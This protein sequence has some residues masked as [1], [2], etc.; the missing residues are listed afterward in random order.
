MEQRTLQPHWHAPS[1]VLCQPDDR[2][3]GTLR[4]GFTLIELLVVIAIIGVLIGLL[5]PA[6]QQA[7]EAARR[8]SCGNSFKQMALALHNYENSLRHYPTA[9]ETNSA[10]ADLSDWSVPAKLLPFLEQVDLGDGVREAIAS[11]TSYTTKTIN[12]KKICN[13]RIDT[14]LC[15]S[16]I[17]NEPRGTDYY[18]LNVAVNM[19]TGTILGSG[20]TPTGDGAF[21][22]NFRGQPQHFSDGLS[23][24]LAMAEVR[25]WTP[26]V[27]DGGGLTT[28]PAGNDLTALQALPG[29]YKADSGHTEWC[30][31]RVHQSGFTTGF[32]PNAVTPINGG[33]DGDF[34][35]SREGG[36]R[37][38]PCIAVVTS[39]SYH[40]GGTV[41]VAMMDGSVSTISSEVPLAIW[42]G[43][44]TRSN[45]E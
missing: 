31:G 5:L 12:G 2:R 23:K 20:N 7:R 14:L 34:T 9:F 16:E 19:G 26:Y 44:G 33:A 40:S 18:P 22:V 17:R 35:T 28:V 11:G 38:A 41:N 39:R 36:N 45:G 43:M 4:A 10:G 27:R 15:P 13:Y 21:G 6:V 24:T 8:L 32:P 29:T 37:T 42:R 25:A 3:T 1:D 30:D